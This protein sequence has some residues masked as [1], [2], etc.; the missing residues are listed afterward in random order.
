[1]TCPSQFVQTCFRST[2]HSVCQHTPWFYLAFIGTRSTNAHVW[3][4][5][6]QLHKR[7][8]A[9]YNQD[10]ED[11]SLGICLQDYTS[12]SEPPAA[13]VLSLAAKPCRSLPGPR[14]SF[15]Q[16]SRVSHFIPE[17]GFEAQKQQQIKVYFLLSN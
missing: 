11:R 3:Q 17:R 8:C 10:V 9:G 5:W 4:K 12:V 6:T 2:V 13:R 14:F 1:M 7:S 16:T 15:N